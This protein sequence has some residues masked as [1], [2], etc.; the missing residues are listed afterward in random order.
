MA[1]R[2]CGF[3]EVIFADDLNAFKEIDNSISDDLAMSWARECQTSL[4]RWGAANRAVF[5]PGKE[6]FHIILRS[7]PA[8]ASF[9][10]LG[11]R[12]DTRLLMHDAIADCV[13]ECGWR[14]HK[15]LRSR[16]YHGTDE[17][18]I[19]FKAHVLSYI[20]YRTAAIHFASTSALAPLDAVLSRFLR[21]LP[22]SDEDALFYH[23]LAPLGTRR[24]MSMLGVI[25]RAVLRKGPPMFHS[26]F[27]L[28]SSSPPRLASRHCR[29]LLDPCNFQDPDYVL[30]SVLGSVSIYNLLPDSIVRASSVKMFQSRLQR[31]LCTCIASAGGVEWRALYSRRGGLAH[32][33]LRL[34]RDWRP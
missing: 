33:P 19:L 30:H 32:H 29:H 6:S 10:V 31:M 4:H 28:D 13:R 26:F 27:R 23:A 24:D 16:R 7:R 12:F 15:L 3:E 11:V 21:A 5:D 25:H 34:F 1:V 14:V 2:A 22:I 20:E 9:K 8:G 18:F 17:L